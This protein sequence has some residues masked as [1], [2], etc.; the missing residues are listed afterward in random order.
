MAAPRRTITLIATVATLAVAAPS[1]ADSSTTQGYGGVAGNTQTDVGQQPTNGSQPSSSNAAPT[2][3]QTVQTKGANAGGNLPFTGA[4]LGML[5][6]GGLVLLVGGFAL[7]RIS[8]EK[9]QS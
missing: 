3:V 2:P 7:R 5:V 1:Y 8:T 9:S 6:A 4:D